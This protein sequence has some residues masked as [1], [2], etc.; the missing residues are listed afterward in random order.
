MTFLL[1]TG[2]LWILAVF[3]VWEHRCYERDLR[4]YLSGRSDGDWRKCAGDEHHVMIRRAFRPAA[5][6]DVLR[7]ALPVLFLFVWLLVFRSWF[8]AGVYIAAMAIK[9][10]AAQTW[11][12]IAARRYE[13]RVFGRSLF[14]APLA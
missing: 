12:D 9:W 3:H 8:P 11:L 13:V 5:G 14:S 6:R 2:F 1:F 7:Y 10:F 4:Q